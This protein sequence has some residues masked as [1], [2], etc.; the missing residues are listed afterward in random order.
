MINKIFKVML[1]SLVCFVMCLAMT[2]CLKDNKK[3]AENIVDDV[4]AAPKEK[5]PVIAPE[6]DK[7]NEAKGVTLGKISGNVY[8]NDYFNFEFT[9]PDDWNKVYTSKEVLMFTKGFN[10][11]DVSKEIDLEELCDL[12]LFLTTNDGQTI[13]VRA[14]K[15]G[16]VSSIWGEISTVDEVME[17]NIG[18]EDDI[19]IDLNDIK[20]VKLGSKEFKC[21]EQS[22]PSN[23]QQVYMYACEADGYIIVFT[24]STAYDER[25]D[26]IESFINS[27]NFK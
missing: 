5:K 17:N 14:L 25:K 8:N 7:T 20:T 27:I 23:V 19:E 13:N 4:E 2:A 21:W 24:A 3:P 10:K 11:V 15:I 9:F 18:F 1:I 12:F 22:L 6:P 26:D 16:M